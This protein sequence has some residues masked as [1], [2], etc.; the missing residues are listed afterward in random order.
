MTLFWWRYC[1]G[2]SKLTS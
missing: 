1:C 2:I